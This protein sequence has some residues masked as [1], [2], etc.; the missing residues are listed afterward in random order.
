MGLAAMGG[1]VAITGR[2]DARTD[3]VA[4]EIRAASG[5]KVDAFVAD[6]SSQ[7]EVRRL[8]DEVLQ[9][10]SRI[11]VLHRRASYPPQSDVSGWRACGQYGAG[12]AP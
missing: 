6:L 12:Y 9:R 7:P 8:A 3:A 4:R 1:Q 11:D 10:C 2:D 5:G